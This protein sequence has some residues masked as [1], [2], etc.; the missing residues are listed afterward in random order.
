MANTVPDDVGDGLAQGYVA[1]GEVLVGK[2]VGTLLG[3]LWLTVV[4]GWITVVEAIVRLHVQILDAIQ[5]AQI[6]VLMAFAEGGAD[7]YRESWSAAF[8]AAVEVDPLV[9][10]AIMSVEIIAVSALALWARR[11]WI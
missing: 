4:A 1:G 9:A 11:R 10:P 3:S 6:A 5:Q 2:L 7:A 8:R